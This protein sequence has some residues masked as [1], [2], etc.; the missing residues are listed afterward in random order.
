MVAVNENELYDVNGG[1]R[2]S[3]PI[4]VSSNGTL[5]QMGADALDE[6]QTYLGEMGRLRQIRDEKVRTMPNPEPKEFKRGRGSFEVDG[7]GRK[8]QYNGGRITEF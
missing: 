6:V 3:A 1:Q 4:P 2:T 7:S 5:L 8:V